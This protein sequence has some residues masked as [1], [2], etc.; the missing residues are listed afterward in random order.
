MA[1][2]TTPHNPVDEALQETELGSF[3]AKNKTSVIGFVALIILGVF[4]WGGYSMYK[5]SKN[6][7]LS[8]VVFE[9][10]NKNLENLTKKTMTGADYTAAYLEMAKSMSGFVGLTPLALASSDVLTSQ[11][12]LENSLKV[13]ATV[14]DQSQSY[15]KYFVYSRMAVNHEDLNQVDNAIADL[16]VI[17]KANIKVM[18]SKTY[19]DL[20]RL[21]LKKGDKEKA[22][23]NFQ[24]VIDNMSQAEFVKLAKLYIAQMES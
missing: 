10:K 3:I 7:E 4:A 22:K 9:F 5:G 23:T 15:I 14:K 11:G 24:Y 8:S 20:G 2:T 21:Y 6:D 17:V 1:T 12:D 18:E 16:E 13:L 19:L